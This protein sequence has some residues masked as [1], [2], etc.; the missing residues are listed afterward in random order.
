MMSAALKV[1][2]RYGPSLP[3]RD[4]ASAHVCNIRI[5]SARVSSDSVTSVKVLRVFIGHSRRKDM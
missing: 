1:P 5:A 2:N 3:K 4:R